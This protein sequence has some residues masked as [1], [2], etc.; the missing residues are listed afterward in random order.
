MIAK[1]GEEPDYL[2]PEEFTKVWL[3]EYEA[4]KELGRIFKK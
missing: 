3:E 1:F 4:R 2:G